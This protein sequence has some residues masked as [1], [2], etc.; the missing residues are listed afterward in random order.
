MPAP[1][2]V[3]LFPE[4]SSTPF[5]ERWANT[6]LEM[7]GVDT[8]AGCLNAKDGPAGCS[9][10]TSTETDSL[11]SRSGWFPGALGMSR[12]SVPRKLRARVTDVARATR[13]RR[14]LISSVFVRPSSM[15]TRSIRRSASLQPVRSSW[16]TAIT[17]LSS[18]IESVTITI[19]L[20]PL[21]TT[22]PTSVR[23]CCRN[24][25]ARK[26]GSDSSAPAPLRPWTTTGRQ[27]SMRSAARHAAEVRPLQGGPTSSVLP[28][29]K[30]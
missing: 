3:G 27:P 11:G 30:L 12:L 19:A 2:A 17:A 20:P 29:S 4:G 8:A 14:S 10:P 22:P 18:V 26:A 5:S 9:P 21:M 7:V 1:L 13:S 24:A 16:S 15:R 28:S 6:S 23:I 25:L